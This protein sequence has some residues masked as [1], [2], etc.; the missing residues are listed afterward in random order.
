MVHK[1]LFEEYI[2]VGHHY[3]HENLSAHNIYMGVLLR[4]SIDPGPSVDFGT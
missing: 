2:F 4:S 1:Y 3:K